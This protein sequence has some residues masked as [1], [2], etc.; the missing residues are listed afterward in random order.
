MAFL[1]IG[2]NVIHEA[3]RK[4]VKG[5]HLIGVYNAGNSRV[6]ENNCYVNI[7]T[8]GRPGTTIF[9]LSVTDIRQ[10]AVLRSAPP[11]AWQT[12]LGSVYE[13]VQICQ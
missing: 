2:Q 8:Q 5:S 13:H 7:M 6:L 12:I 1:Q 9:V 10:H 3:L 4:K 11:P